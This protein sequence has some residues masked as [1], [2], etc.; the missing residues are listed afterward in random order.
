M[1]TMTHTVGSVTAFSLDSNI[2]SLADGTA[3]PLGTV[4]N[5][6]LEYS[7]ARLVMV[8]NL[9]T[10]EANL[11]V[12]GVIELYFVASLEDT[13]WSDG[14][15]P[16]STSDQMGNIKN[17]RLIQAFRADKSMAGLDVTWVC[18]DLSL[19]VDKEGNKVGEMP[20]YWSLIVANRSGSAIQASGNIASYQMVTYGT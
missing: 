17:A 6:S 1:A 2:D 11:D 20:P 13:Y 10:T 15:D 16:D 4:D 19:M 8:F 3:K 18:S 9:E 7:T 14:I 12:D 5:S